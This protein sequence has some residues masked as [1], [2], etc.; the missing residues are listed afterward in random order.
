MLEEDVKRTAAAA[1]NCD[2]PRH[3]IRLK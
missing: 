2:R 1:A 3:D